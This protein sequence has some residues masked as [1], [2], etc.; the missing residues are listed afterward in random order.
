MCRCL[1]YCI[2]T[3][4]NWQH[5]GPRLKIM[6]RLFVCNHSFAYSSCTAGKNI[7]YVSYVDSSHRTRRTWLRK[8]KKKT[9]SNSIKKI[10][11]Y[12]K[13]LEFWE[14]FFPQIKLQDNWVLYEMRSMVYIC[15]NILN[16]FPSGRGESMSQLYFV[17]ILLQ[18]VKYCIRYLGKT[19]VPVSSIDKVFCR[20]IK[21]LG[22]KKK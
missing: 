1:C 13:I 2:R 16:H 15:K 12:N 17:Y 11:F 14:F 8:T 7:R 19:W 18:N 9:W 20:R 10:V 6:L 21:Y 22:S 3:T 4:E 5:Q